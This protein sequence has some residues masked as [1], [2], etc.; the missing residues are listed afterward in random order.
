MND[1]RIKYLPPAE[2]TRERYEK[3]K[4]LFV[5]IGF[6]N[7]P[8]VDN[9]NKKFEED[10]IYLGLDLDPEKIDKFSA[11]Y[12][13]SP[14]IQFKKV[15]GNKD[16]FHLPLLDGSADEVHIANVFGI[17]RAIDSHN[18]QLLLEE[19]IRILREGGT[20]SVLETLTPN[21]SK[22]TFER[23][24][25]TYPLLKIILSIS[26]HSPEWQ[27]EIVKYDNSKEHWNPSIASNRNYYLIKAEKLLSFVQ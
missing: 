19:S 1:G 6:G 12:K 23:L 21:Y 14:N 18:L 9:G 25:R 22:D 5:D 4:R 10:E 27:E 8:V 20:L 2:I 17:P 13:N 26:P 11:K 15:G 24:L 7:Y 3:L 16:N